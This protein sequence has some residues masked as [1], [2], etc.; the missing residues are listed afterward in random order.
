M[1]GAL[2]QEQLAR[3]AFSAS[4]ELET[5]RDQEKR[6]REQTEGKL[7]VLAQAMGGIVHDLG[8]P[9]NVVKMGAQSMELFLEDEPIDRAALHEFSQAITSGVEMLNYLRLSLIEQTRVLEGKPIPL[10]L[11]RA[12]LRGLVEAGV[13][14]QSPQFRTGREVSIAGEERAVQVDLMK[15]T[16]VF[17]NL[18]GNAL[19]YSD[20][21]IS[22]TWREVKRSGHELVLVAV[23]DRGTR[24][25]GITQA[26]AALLFTAFARLE[27]HVHVEG[28]GLGLLSVLK[29]VAAHGGE[30]FIEGHEDGTPA[31]PRFSTARDQYPSLLPAEYRTAFVVTCPL[32]ATSP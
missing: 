3:R 9:L 18:I 31:S 26:Q 8:N 10:D 4:H 19:K 11:A 20:G 27:T 21:E 13:R 23:L 25:S 12:S 2:T 14:Y 15:M 16:T 30:S 17:M 29:I 7:H 24:G 1:L 22:V 32:A 5:E 28:T 6:Q